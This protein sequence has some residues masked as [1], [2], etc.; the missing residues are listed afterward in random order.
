MLRKCECGSTPSKLI[1]DADNAPRIKIIPDCCRY[2]T[3]T[4]LINSDDIEEIAGLSQLEWNM[5]AIQ[6]GELPEKYNV[7]IMD[8]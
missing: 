3:I 5:V 8:I 4:V 6:N 2:H 1:I 7:N